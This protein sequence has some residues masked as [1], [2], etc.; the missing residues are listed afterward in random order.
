MYLNVVRDEKNSRH[1]GQLN[2]TWG[3]RWDGW[4][5]AGKNYSW[6]GQRLP[7]LE[8]DLVPAGQS[9]MLGPSHLKMSL[10][11]GSHTP[12][13]FMAC[14]GERPVSSSCRPES[15]TLFLQKALGSG[16]IPCGSLT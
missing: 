14:L 7:F 4:G 10:S 15:Q 11:S 9:P 1:Q 12:A 13:C 8:I 3:T 16:I 2:R 5:G 6:Q